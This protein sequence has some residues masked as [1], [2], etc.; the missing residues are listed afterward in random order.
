MA[1]DEILFPTNISYGSGGGP[2]FRSIVQEWHDGGELRIS[3]W[4]LPRR[5]WN[6]TNNVRTRSR[7]A[8]LLDFYRARGGPENGFRFEDWLDWSTTLTHNQAPGAESDPTDPSFD[9]KNLHSLGVGDAIGSPKRTYQCVKRYRHSGV[10]RVRPITK[11]KLATDPK[12]D[13]KLYGHDRALGGFYAELT[14][15]VAYTVD[16]NTGIVTYEQTLPET[17]ELLWS[18]T[19][20]VPAQF[21]PKVSESFLMQVLTSIVTEGAYSFAPINLIEIP[22]AIEMAEPFY[23]GGYGTVAFTVD[24]QL[25]FGDGM[26]QA[27]TPNAASKSVFLPDASNVMDGWPIMY[28]FNDGPNS[29]T[30]KQQDDTTVVTTFA[31]G[32]SIELGV[33]SGNWVAR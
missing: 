15:G 26:A 13:F 14:E 18:G 25:S 12:E 8:A 21:D 30:V 33:Y 24:T 29:C 9:P 1:F 5:T 7:A 20:D 23:S 17:T 27:L 28:L 4:Q 31:S 2:G 16:R 19:F 22:S 11:L 32:E 10:E 3:Q 6:V